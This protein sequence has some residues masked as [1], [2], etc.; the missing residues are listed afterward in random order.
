MLMLD[1]LS[2]DTENLHD[3]PIVIAIAMATIE[4][5]RASMH[6]LLPYPPSVLTMKV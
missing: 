5:G 6:F 4:E 3:V 1:L 2:K